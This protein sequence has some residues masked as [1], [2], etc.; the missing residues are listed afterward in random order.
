M[1]ISSFWF[2]PLNSVQFSLL[3]FAGW[4]A[5]ERLEIVHEPGALEGRCLLASCIGPW[6]GEGVF[7]GLG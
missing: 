3:V 7:L 6:G 2:V 4:F 1:S 5:K